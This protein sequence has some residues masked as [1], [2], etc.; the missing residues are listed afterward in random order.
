MLAIYSPI[1]SPRVDL[2]Q[3]SHF[4]LT[5]G[6]HFILFTFNSK[7]SNLPMAKTISFESELDDKLAIFSRLCC[8]VT[9]FDVS[10]NTILDAL[11]D[12]L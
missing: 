12:L 11:P 10:A 1:S 8:S 7:V 6:Y 2:G 9:I 3:L 4:R 5:I